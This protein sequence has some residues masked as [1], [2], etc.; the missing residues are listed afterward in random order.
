MKEDLHFIKFDHTKHDLSSAKGEVRSLKG[1]IFGD[2]GS[3]ASPPSDKVIAKMPKG[4]KPVYLHNTAGATHVIACDGTSLLWAEITQETSELLDDDFSII[5]GIKNAD[6]ITVHD[7]ILYRDNIVIASNLGLLYLHH[8]GNKYICSYPLTAPE[9]DFGLQKAGNLTSN[10][11]IVVPASSSNYSGTTRPNSVETTLGAIDSSVS[12]ALVSAFDQAVSAQITSKGYFHMPFLLRYALRL[13]DGSRTM[14]SPPI[15]MLPTVLPPLIGV[16]ISTEETKGVKSI[17]PSLSRV[18]YHQLRY[19][20]RNI[21][22]SNISALVAA[23]DVFATPIIPTY[24]T[25]SSS[26]GHITTYEQ[27]V[28]AGYSPMRGRDNASSS[29]SADAVY[30]GLFSDGKDNYTDHFLEQSIRESTALML[31]PN[32][33]I[34][35]QI[36]NASD[37]RL[38]ASIPIDEIENDGKFH[39]LPISPANNSVNITNMVVDD[40]ISHYNII[41]SKLCSVNGH[42]MAATKS[43]L[44]K[45]GKLLPTLPYYGNAAA[46]TSVNTE[47]SV[48]IKTGNQIS[49]IQST[50]TLNFSIADVFPKYIYVPHKGAYIICMRQG[51]NIRTLNLTPHTSLSGAYWYGGIYN[52]EMPALSA[53]E[54]IIPY[55]SPEINED[56][57]VISNKD[58]PYIFD[59]RQSISID[60]VSITAIA[61]ATKAPKYGTFGKYPAYVFT[62]GGIWM[63]EYSNA[64]QQ[65]TSVNKINA[66]ACPYG[67]AVA[68]AGNYIMYATDSQIR[69]LESNDSKTISHPLDSLKWDITTLP[70]ANDL[71]RLGESQQIE[72]SLD[73]ILKNGICYYHKPL[74]MLLISSKDSGYTLA[75]RC[76]AWS[77]I[78]LD[79]AGMVKS[80]D[81][82]VYL[83][84]SDGS[85]CCLSDE[86]S[87]SKA[88]IVTRP[89]HIDTYPICAVK[90]LGNLPPGQVSLAVY[91]AHS[92]GSWH[93][94]ASSTGYYARIYSTESYYLYTIV[95]LAELRGDG[96]V[97]GL[98]IE[99]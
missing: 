10:I 57:I 16:A 87:K 94:C 11:S 6:S 32:T 33:S 26:H 66:D 67:N 23:I 56:I 22:T 14:P 62:T 77:V 71:L 9:I 86:P 52:R 74:S 92:V 88:L 37:F 47:I 5:P 80:G 99:Y 25:S 19:R 12:E 75:Y 30:D 51:E 54:P 61:E 96:W 84:K 64:K 55:T 46:E 53:N 69:L 59:E 8:D 15:L 68:A 95:I 1:L 48:Y 89:I 63:L 34:H 82:H 39:L 29:G 3:L 83:Y 70:H 85:I 24:D 50:T 97:S 4:I 43:F 76:G 21:D 20:I 42:L 2:D 98:E 27:V 81:S 73:E 17:R 79:V 93:L 31:Y 49:K 78:D 13:Y 58:N 7:A 45:D 65:F 35:E 36:A 40:S 41:A 28:N 90:V 91:G 38:I 44:P 18:T 60:G 72:T